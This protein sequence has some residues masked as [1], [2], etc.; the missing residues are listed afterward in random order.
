VCES[1]RFGAAE[2]S[3]QS[4]LC[5][6]HDMEHLEEVPTPERLFSEMEL[7]E[8]LEQHKPEFVPVVGREA[9]GPLPP[10]SLCSPSKTIFI[11]A[12]S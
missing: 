2:E 6:E 3:I 11:G 1:C 8:L 5:E 4:A 7:N 12:V 10:R 9:E